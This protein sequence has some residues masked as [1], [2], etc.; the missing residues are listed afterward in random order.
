MSEVG[1]NIFLSECRSTSLSIGK[2][3]WI[4]LEAKDVRKGMRRVEK[5]LELSSRRC[6]V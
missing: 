1:K 2:E 6:A 4:A 3:R 5:N